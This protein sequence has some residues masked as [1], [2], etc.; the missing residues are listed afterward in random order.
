[1]QKN[2][3]FVILIAIS[4]ALPVLAIDEAENPVLQD[5][6]EIVNTETVNTIEEPLLQT[7]N[8]EEKTSVM[9]SVYKQPISKRKVAKR[10]LLAMF[11]VVAS[12]VIIF[13]GLSLYNKFR[14]LLFGGNKSSTLNEDKEPSLETPDDI[15]GAVKSFI[16]KTKWDE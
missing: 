10:F 14:E 16:N 3:I 6:T 9:D 13:L 12:S 5:N 4:L 15:V 8:A 11:G 1:M 2:K 7:D